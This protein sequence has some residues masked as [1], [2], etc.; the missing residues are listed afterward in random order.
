VS[1][2]FK[3]RDIS[4]YQQFLG[5]SDTEFVGVYNYFND[6]YLKENS[7]TLTQWLKDESFTYTAGASGD[8]RETILMRLQGLNLT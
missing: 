7:G 4:V 3:D 1:S 5:L 8:L 6:L 2:G